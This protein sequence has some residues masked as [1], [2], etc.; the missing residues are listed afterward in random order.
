MFFKF[1]LHDFGYLSRPEYDAA[2]LELELQA[3]ARHSTD[4]L[5]NRLQFSD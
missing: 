1:M 4:V 5:G 3:V 2:A